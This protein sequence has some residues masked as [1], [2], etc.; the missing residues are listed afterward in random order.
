MD[1]VQAPNELHQIHHQ[2]H[3]LRTINSKLPMVGEVAG[4]YKSTLFS[5]VYLSLK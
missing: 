4:L 2:I 3:H 5:L 1:D